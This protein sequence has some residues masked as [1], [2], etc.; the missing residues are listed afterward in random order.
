[1]ITILEQGR[2]R[3]LRLD[4]PP[5]NALSPELLQRLVTAVTE[6]PAAGAEAIVLSGQEGVFSAGLDVPLLL[7]LERP[8]LAEAVA[9]L[10]DACE[11]LASSALPVVAALT[12]HSPGGG[13]VLSLF[14]DRRVIAEGAY[15]IGMNE[16]VVGLPMP[17]MILAALVRQVGPRSA[18]QLSVSGRM[19]T[20]AQALE[21]GLVDEVAP[22][23]EV[24]PRAHAWCEE[25]IALPRRAMRL[26]RAASR[27]DLV[28]L[29]VEHGARDRERFATEWFEPEV[30]EALKQLVVR[31]GKGPV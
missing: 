28:D 5:V 3:E 1:M 16:V 11:A 22:L 10:F 19:L 25:V 29:V 17:E 24:V 14:C 26:T 12:G 15:S 30:Q 9:L 23:D 2:I 7:G 8:A 21:V 31:L 13:A 6:A 18:E 4:R 20:P 27:R